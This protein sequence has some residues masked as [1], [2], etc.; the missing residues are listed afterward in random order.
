MVKYSIGMWDSTY[1][2]SIRLNR[3]NPGIKYERR[4]EFVKDPGIYFG[5]SG[6]PVFL[7]AGDPK[8]QY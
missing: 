1:Q 8:L 5:L 3:H 6:S 2:F 4:N 7:I